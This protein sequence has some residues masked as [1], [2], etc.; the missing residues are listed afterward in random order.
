MRP[1]ACRQHSTT[2]TVADS[3]DEQWYVFV[4]DARG[5]AE[6]SATSIPI[7]VNRDP[8][9]RVDPTGYFYGDDLLAATEEGSWIEYVITN[10]DNG[11]EQ[12]KHT[13]AVLQRLHLR[14]RLVRITQLYP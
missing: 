5:P 14:L 11:E 3:V 2:T 8:A 10:P 12:L 7:C 13:W 1:P 6:R 4:V 9:L